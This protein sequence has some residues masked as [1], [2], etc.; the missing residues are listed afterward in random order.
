MKRIA[1]WILAFL[2]AGIAVI[3]Y[4]LGITQ[5]AGG[6]WE[7]VLVADQ[8]EWYGA[9][10]VGLLVVIALV[11]PGIYL[12]IFLPVFI[13]YRLYEGLQRFGIADELSPNQESDVN[14]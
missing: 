9:K 13:A 8:N 3:A 14:A 10:P 7:M 6:V 11:P 4:L 5:I 2:S 12:F 1:Y